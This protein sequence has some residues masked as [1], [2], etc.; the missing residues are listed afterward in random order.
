[1]F[2]YAKLRL[3]KSDI[4]FLKHLPFSQSLLLNN[5]KVLC[6][7]GS[8]RDISESM[9]LEIPDNEI[10]EMINGGEEDIILC[11]QFHAS[12]NRVVNNKRIINP[13]SIGLPM[14]GDTRASY[15]ILEI[16]DDYKVNF[17]T[18]RIKYDLDENLRLAKSLKFP[19]FDEYE[20]KLRLTTK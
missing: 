13:G 14:D 1:M 15:G 6:V 5:K 18:I 4:E 10:F 7:H 20:K 2:Q 12:T 19:Y 16:T 8:P 3:T 11:G 9:A 17:I